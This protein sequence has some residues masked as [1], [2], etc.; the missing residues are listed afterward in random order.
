MGTPIGEILP[1][2]IC[3]LFQQTTKSYSIAQEHFK[4]P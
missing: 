2:Q 4:W 1:Q 3:A